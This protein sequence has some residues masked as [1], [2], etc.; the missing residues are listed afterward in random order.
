MTENLVKTNSPFMVSLSLKKC[1]ES[2]SNISSQFQPNN[3][4]LNLEEKKLTPKMLTPASQKGHDEFLNCSEL[5]KILDKEFGYYLPRFSRSSGKYLRGI[6]QGT[7][8][9]LKKS[10][11]VYHDPEK[12]KGHC[13]KS[14]LKKWGKYVQEYLPDYESCTYPDKRFIFD[15]VNTL[16]YAKTGEQPTPVKTE[17]ETPRQD[18]QKSSKKPSPLT[19]IENTQIRQTPQFSKSPPKNSQL[20]KPKPIKPYIDLELAG[21]KRKISECPKL[22]YV[23]KNKIFCMSESVFKFVQKTPKNIENP[24]NAKNSENIQNKPKY[25]QIGIQTENNEIQE[26]NEKKCVSTMKLD[27]NLNE[28][29]IRK[30]GIKL[31]K[32]NKT[33]VLSAIDLKNIVADMENELQIFKEK[34]EKDMKM[35]DKNI[36]SFLGLKFTKIE[37]TELKNK[38][39]E[40][41]KLE[42]N[43]EN[44]TKR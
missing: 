11:I 20:L 39:L 27:E 24:E 22:E 34:I 17:V 5:Y 2:Q 40:L 28:W 42:E 25:E 41:S 26:K 23:C 3:S 7:K 8:K 4:A 30:Y 12:F 33:I 44:I 37:H 1:P 38:K 36:C 6:Y 13:I 16:L 15:I 35:P 14:A 32:N 43:K 9:A 31:E 29:I 10:E 19:P 18:A 21:I